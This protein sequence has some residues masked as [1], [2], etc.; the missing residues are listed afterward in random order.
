M[1]HRYKKTTT[2]HEN[3]NKLAGTLE[4]SHSQRFDTLGSDNSHRVNSPG[5]QFQTVNNKCD[6]KLEDALQL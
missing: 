6:I 4:N 5:K 1:Y 3:S 2:S